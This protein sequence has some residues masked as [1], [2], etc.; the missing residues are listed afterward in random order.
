MVRAEAFQVSTLARVDL[1]DRVWILNRLP[2]SP[3]HQVCMEASVWVRARHISVIYQLALTLD[4]FHS[5]STSSKR[6]ERR[7]SNQFSLR[8]TL[9]SSMVGEAFTQISQTTTQSHHSLLSTNLN[10][11]LAIHQPFTLNKSGSRKRKID[12]DHL[13]QSIERR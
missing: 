9:D 10:T 3:K 4:L 13:H 7:S 11:H 1:R 2:I 5:H 8:K 6:Q 12:L